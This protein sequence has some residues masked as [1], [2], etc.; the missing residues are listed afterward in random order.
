MKTVTQRGY[1][2]DG[3][4]DNVYFNEEFGKVFPF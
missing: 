2:K 4:A 3:R 1:T